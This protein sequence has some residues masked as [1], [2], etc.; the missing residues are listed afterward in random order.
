[1][2]KE[3]DFETYLSISD[4]GFEIYLFDKKNL[5]NLYEQKLKTINSL[6]LIDFN[7]L[8]VFLD[9]NIFKIEKLTGKFIKNI[10]IIIDNKK[11]FNLNFCLKKKNYQETLNKKFIENILTDANDLFRENYQ[12]QKIMHLLIRKYII[13]GNQYSSFRD[14][15]NGENFS[16]EVQFISIPNNFLY[17]IDKVLKKY[18]IKIIE[19]FDGNYINNLIEHDNLNIS[20]VAF[21]VQNGL[22]ENEVKLIPKNHKK[23]GFFEK[24]FQLFS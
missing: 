20:E 19:C 12:N 16:V 5:I 4:S 11:I 8:N 13:D 7:L 24:F 14:N 15:F 6:D 22:I 23:K 17:E 9:K 1:M 2:N 21:K 3:S 10:I 18:Q